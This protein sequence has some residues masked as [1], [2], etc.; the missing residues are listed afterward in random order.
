MYGTEKYINFGRND[1]KEIYNLEDTH[2][3]GRM[4]FQC[5]VQKWSRI[6]WTGLIW[7]RTLVS[8]GISE[9]RFAQEV[10]NLFD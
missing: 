2:A 6:M 1:R 4:K 5:T 9:L 8:D 10:A 3:D 7:L